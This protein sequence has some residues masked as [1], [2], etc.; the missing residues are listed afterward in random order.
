MKSVVQKNTLNDTSIDKQTKIGIL[1]W[2]LAIYLFI[3]PLDFLPI[4]P[5]VSLSKVLIFIPL[6]GVLLQ[7]KQITARIDKYFVVPLIYVLM[8]TLTMYYTYNIDLTK[9]RIITVATNV[10]VILLLSLFKYSEKEIQTIKQAIIY[11]GWFTLALMI[12]YSDTDIMA[13]RMTVIVNGV[14]QDP[15]YLTGFLIFSIISYFDDFMKNK[16][17]TSFIKM[18]IFMFFVFLTGSRGGLVAVLGAL[19]FYSFI[20]IK[21]EKVSISFLITLF[22]IILLMSIFVTA[23]L[24][25]LPES[26]SERFDISFTIN[27]KGANRGGIWQN[28]L[29]NYENSPNFNKIFGWGAGTI[30]RLTSTGKVA[31]NLWIESLMET[32]I[33]GTSILFLFYGIFVI[34]ASKLREFV[35]ASSFI[36]YII[37]TMSMSLYSFKPIWN[38]IFL[39]LILKNRDSRF[40]KGA[41]K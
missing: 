19:L 3:A 34:K 10:I 24:S 8:I 35:A 31:H 16:K 33:I 14:Y 5:G 21:K 27:D 36:G 11:S 37:M 13:G 30:T 6:I 32:G 41:S 2:F 12:F 29:Y 9:E 40:K 4:I 23:S 28:I 26:V 18:I 20:W 17:F 39:I 38:I 15:N 25:L 1:S 22:K 7:I